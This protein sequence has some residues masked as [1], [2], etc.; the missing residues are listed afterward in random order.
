MTKCCHNTLCQDCA[1]KC[2]QNGPNIWKCPYCNNMESEN[3]ELVSSDHILRGLHE[4][5]LRVKQAF[6]LEHPSDASGI[7]SQN[8][9]S[10]I[11]QK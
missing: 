7:S 3:C 10:Q 9:V 6:C 11:F 1:D 8:N 2:V 5:V 4:N